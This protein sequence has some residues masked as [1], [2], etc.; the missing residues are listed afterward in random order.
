MSDLGKRLSHM[1]A[2]ALQEIG[3]IGA[4]HATVALSQ[5]IEKKIN[6]TVTRVELLGLEEFINLVGKNSLVI[7]V[8]L[9]ILIEI[10][11]GIIVLFIKESAFNLVDILLKQ[12]AG[13]TKDL[14]DLEQSALKETG[15]ILSA[16]Y[17]N[18][19]SDLMKL[20]LIPSVP[21]IISDTAEVVM[22]SIFGQ[23]LTEANIMLTIEN[24]F[25]EADNKIKGYFL[26]IPGEKGV[27]ALL[28]SLGI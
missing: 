23:L 24:E 17:L 3:N 21:K 9:K 12:P 13:R 18:A 26:F 19:L 2:S 11:A 1:Q 10:K 27:E 28:K 8:Y 16:A 4:G 25:V 20:T 5:L 22:L 7:G 15:S 6:L 14:G